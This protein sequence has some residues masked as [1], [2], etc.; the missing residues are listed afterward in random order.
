M[1]AGYRNRLVHFYQEVSPE[2]LYQICARQLGDLEQ[3]LRAYR[4]WLREHPE[5]LDEML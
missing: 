1:L 3:I 5:M 2:E 4:G